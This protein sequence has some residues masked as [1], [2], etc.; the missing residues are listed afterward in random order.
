MMLLMLN[1]AEGCSC[2]TMLKLN[3]HNECCKINVH[4]EHTHEA[5]MLQVKKLH[6]EGGERL[7][8]MVR[9]G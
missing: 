6:A 3:V 7:M 5:F 9:K 2:C 8:L 4:A 1:E